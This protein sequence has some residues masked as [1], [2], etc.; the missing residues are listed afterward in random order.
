MNSLGAQIAL[1]MVWLFTDLSDVM[2]LLGLAGGFATL[3]KRLLNN[4]IPC[5]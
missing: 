2:L 1:A 3:G 5:A 4:P